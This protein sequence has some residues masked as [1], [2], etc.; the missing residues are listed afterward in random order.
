M[1]FHSDFAPNPDEPVIHPFRKN[2]I[3]DR[4]EP[5]GGLWGEV[6]SR[7]DVSR[8]D[9]AT[10]VDLVTPQSHA[11]LKP[12]C[13]LTLALHSADTIAKIPAPIDCVECK[14]IGGNNGIVGRTWDT[15]HQKET[16]HPVGSR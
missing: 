1:V 6:G 10:E 11:N 9:N 3:V 4:R 5:R 7:F 12:A 8:R 16:H 13:L 14:P 15:D 2:E